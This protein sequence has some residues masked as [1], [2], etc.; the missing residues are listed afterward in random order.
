MKLYVQFNEFFKTS[1]GIDN[2]IPDE[3]FTLVHH[4][5]KILMYTLNVVRCLVRCPLIINS[6]Y[7]NEK[8]NKSVG[9]VSTSLHLKG[10]AADITCADMN[11]LHQVCK[12][13]YNEGLFREFIYYADKEFIHVAI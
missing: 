8:V 13:L 11:K 5:V 12:T 4:N 1:T 9:G 10:C 2:S 3:D 6:G 7:R